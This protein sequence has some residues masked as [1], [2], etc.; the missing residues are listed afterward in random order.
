MSKMRSK[1]ESVLTWKAVVLGGICGYLLATFTQSSD[2]EW[3]NR[4]QRRWLE[5]E[6]SKEHYGGEGSEEE[7]E[8]LDPVS[9]QGLVL[10]NGV[11]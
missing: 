5:A 11:T 3:T 1:S 2:V 4:S 8:A 10:R 7:E 9:A 6:A